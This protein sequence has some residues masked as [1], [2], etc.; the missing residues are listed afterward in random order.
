MGRILTTEANDLPD[1]HPSND[2]VVCTLYEGDFHLGVATLINSIVQGGF[3]GL[4]W[5]G[6]RGVLPPWVEQLSRLEN[7]LFRVGDATLGFETI[8]SSRHFGQYKPQFMRSIIDRGIARGY[9]WYS[10]PDIT[11][12]CPWSF[13]ERW[14]RFGVCVCQD[15]HTTMMASNHP[16]RR[17]WITLAHNAGWGEPIHRRERY[18]NSGYVGL[19]IEHS[20]FLDVWIDSVL[21]ANSAGVQQDQFQKGARSQTFYTVDQDT[22][23][24]ASMY[25]QVPFTTIGP[26]GMGWV[27]GGF[28]MYHSVGHL[29]PWRKKFL[30]AALHGNPPSNGDKHFLQCAAGPIHPYTP[31]QLKRRRW[32][33]KLAALIGRFYRRN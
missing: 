10:D 13:V 25:A 5:V 18:F 7:G 24:I 20:A 12:R 28:T 3:K 9:L 29:K 26:E 17:E 16:I 27:P 23:N 1:I 8:K 15:T 32:Q 22:L 6:H 4:F 2:Q 21:L 11:V 33:A 31:W 30:R 19:A 14:I